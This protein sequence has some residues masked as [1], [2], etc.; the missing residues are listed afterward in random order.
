MV[1]CIDIIFLVVFGL[2][3]GGMVLFGCVL[4]GRVWWILLVMLLVCG[5]IIICRLLV[6]FGCIMVI[7]L[8]VLSWVFEVLLWLIR[9]RCRCVV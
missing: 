2:F 4:K 9:C 1:V 7:V 6:L 8:R 3:S 5:L